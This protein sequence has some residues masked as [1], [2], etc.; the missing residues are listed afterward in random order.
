MSHRLIN[1]ACALVLLAATSAHA[2]TLELSWTDPALDHTNGT[3]DLT[4]MSLTIDNTTGEFEIQADFNPDF[5]FSN[6]TGAFYIV[7]LNLYNT[8][9]PNDVTP[10]EPDGVL[11]SVN[12]IY[13]YVVEP[14]TQ[15]II[16]GIHTGY[17]GW[18]AGDEI[19][20][21]SSIATPGFIYGSGVSH[22]GQ[23][24]D[25]VDAA[26]VVILEG[27]NCPGDFNA[28]GMVGATDLATLLGNW[29][30]ADPTYDLDGSGDVGAGDLADLL[31]RWDP[32]PT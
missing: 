14:T 26:L 7:N 17:I 1:S 27:A 10:E 9:N 28:D 16:T 13:E 18:Q 4:G 3:I 6:P 15:L 25:G 24:L 5:P 2:A 29:G 12:T 30:S 11:V 23:G 8:T 19:A 20:N 32:C 22:G 21:S 31:G